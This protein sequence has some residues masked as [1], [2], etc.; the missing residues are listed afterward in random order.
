MDLQYK[1]KVQY[2][3]T[4]QMGVV[5]H[6]NYA[7]Y[8]EEARLHIWDEMG[9][10]YSAMEDLGIMIPVLSCAAEFKRPLR[11]PDEFVLSLRWEEVS[12]V[13]FRVHYDFR[14]C[15]DG[16]LAA[17]GLTEHCFADKNLKP[18]R[19]QKQFPAVYEEI[20]KLLE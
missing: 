18:M 10:S 1:R 13:R 11:F 17:T 16:R 4:D 7:R 6:S 12:G 20:K 15:E 8:M 14:L 2:Y 5:H 9:L 3:E 19:I